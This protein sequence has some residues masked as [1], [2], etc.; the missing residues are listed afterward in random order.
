MGRRTTQYIVLGALLLTI[1]L[2]LMYQFRRGESASE[3]AETLV[4]AAA[5][6]RGATQPK[7]AAGASAVA[8]VNLAALKQTPPEPETTARNPFRLKPP[9]APPM[10]PRG[11]AGMAGA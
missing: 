9:P 2:A 6:Q 1:A 3:P 4:P 11:R 5:P 8:D 10:P 7:R